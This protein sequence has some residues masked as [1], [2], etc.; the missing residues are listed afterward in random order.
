MQIREDPKQGT[1]I[2]GLIESIIKN[3]KKFLTTIKRGA[4]SRYLK[5]KANKKSHAILQMFIEQRWVEKLPDSM[6]VNVLISYRLIIQ[7][8]F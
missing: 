5:D 3:K 8:V 1:Y 7:I 6:K 4:K 2:E